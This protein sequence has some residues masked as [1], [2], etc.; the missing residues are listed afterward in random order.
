MAREIRNIG[1]SVRARTL[2]LPKASGQGSGLVLTH[3]C[4][5]TP[6]LLSRQPTRNTFMEK[7]LKVC[8]TAPIV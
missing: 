6:V 4:T 2:N 7:A 8:Y 1:A 3:F 5:G